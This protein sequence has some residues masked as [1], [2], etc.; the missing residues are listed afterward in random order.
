M[1]I[2]IKGEPKEIDDLVLA[3]QGRQ[4]DSP[5]DY[6]EL[7]SKLFRETFRMSREL[8]RVSCNEQF[9]REERF[10]VQSRY[11]ALSEFLS[12][13]GLAKEY[14]QWERRAHHEKD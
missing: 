13:T 1:E 9:S 4:G 2:I 14:L 8:D 12:K 5:G 7:K 3:V 10:S 6:E 11:N